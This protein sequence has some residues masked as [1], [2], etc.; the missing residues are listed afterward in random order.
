MGSD[1]FSGCGSGSSDNDSFHKG[2]GTSTNI[3]AGVAFFIWLVILL[4]IIWLL[5]SIGIRWFSTI[6]FS[7]IVATFILTLFF[8][9]RFHEGK[10]IH[11]SEDAL[12]GLI[13]LVTWILVIIYIIWKVFSDRDPHRRGGW[14]GGQ[15]YGHK[16]TPPSSMTTIKVEGPSVP[17]APSP[18]V[19]ATMP[20]APATAGP[21]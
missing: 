11:K 6:V 8:P 15:Y 13:H 3:S 19:A 12:F 20:T 5:R 16:G 1:W 2:V 14:W 7:F 10:Y 18:A 17:V 21:F 9:L 4:I